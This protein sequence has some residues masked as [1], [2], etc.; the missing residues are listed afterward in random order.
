MQIVPRLWLIPQWMAG[1]YSK[2][3]GA[4]VQFCS[5]KGVRGHLSHWIQIQGLELD[6][7]FPEP[8]PDVDC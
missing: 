5:A 7:S 4:L 8:V 3:S 2:T 1:C 6:H